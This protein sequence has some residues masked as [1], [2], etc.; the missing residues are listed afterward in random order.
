MQA[1]CHAIGDLV[2]VIA[3]NLGRFDHV[4]ADELDGGV[5]HSRRV[6]EQMAFDRAPYISLSSVQIRTFSQTS[7]AYLREDRR[8]AGNDL[9]ERT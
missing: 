9:P 8:I 7:S 5:A 3:S 2:V 1:Y 6:V 4:F